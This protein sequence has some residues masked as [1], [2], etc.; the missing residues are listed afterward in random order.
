MEFNTLCWNELNARDAAACKKFY[1]AVFGWTAHDQ[2]FGPTI[3]P[4]S[5]RV[6]SKSP[7]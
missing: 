3:T 5:R 7:A 4:Y 1:T 2:V 6:S